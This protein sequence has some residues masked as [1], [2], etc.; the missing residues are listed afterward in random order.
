MSKTVPTINELRVWQRCGCGDQYPNKNKEN[1]VMSAQA[2]TGGSAHFQQV[3]PKILEP[4]QV[5]T[6]GERALSD[7]MSCPAAR[8]AR[9]VWQVTESHHQGSWEWGGRQGWKKLRS[10][11]PNGRIISLLHSPENE[12]PV[13]SGVGR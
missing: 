8:A 5:R 13:V 12:S 3:L 6:G 7:Q 11:G 4:Q 2:P 1:N 10:R 9:C